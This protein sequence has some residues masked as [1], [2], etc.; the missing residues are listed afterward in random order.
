MA[1]GAGPHLPV[2]VDFEEQGQFDGNQGSESAYWQTHR[3]RDK[4][5]EKRD[6]GTVPT[7]PIRYKEGDE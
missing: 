1:T 3:G 7:Y 6:L 5:A 4:T 2:D